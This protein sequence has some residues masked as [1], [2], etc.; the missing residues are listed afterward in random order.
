MDKQTYK[1]MLA[2]EMSKVSELENEINRLQILVAKYSDQQRKITKMVYD[3]SNNMELGKKIRNMFWQEEKDEETN[4][5]SL[6]ENN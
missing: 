2:D 3:N 5:M 4:Q 1:E 6:F